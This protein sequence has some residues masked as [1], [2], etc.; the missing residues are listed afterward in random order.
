M[1]YVEKLEDLE[2]DF[3]REGRY[4]GLAGGGCVGGRGGL[5]TCLG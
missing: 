1:D 2:V 5:V 3:G 4:G